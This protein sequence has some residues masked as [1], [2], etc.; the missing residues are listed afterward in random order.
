[1]FVP[2]WGLASFNSVETSGVLT[3]HGVPFYPVS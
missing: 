3:L 1:M 2:Q